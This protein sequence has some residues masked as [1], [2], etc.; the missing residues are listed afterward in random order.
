MSEPAEARTTVSFDD[1]VAERFQ[2]LLRFGRVLTGSTPAAEDLV[3]TAL[4]K[5]YPKWDRIEAADPE[6][7]VRRVMANTHAS[8]WRRPWR[9]R[10]YEEPPERPASGPDPYV[11]LE[12]RDAVWQAL[13]QL[14][15]RQRTALVLRFYEE[16]SM[17]EIAGALGC[18]NGTAKSLVSRGL[19]ALRE[20]TG[21]HE[22]SGLDT[23]TGAETTKLT[24]TDDTS[25]GGHSGGRR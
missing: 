23:D 24:D 4:T 5:T 13:S 9:E 2:P 3:Q 20:T 10:P 25:P 18:R 11:N 1:F 6:G 15:S 8:W 22:A 14:S 17:D 21:L 19:A 7:Y 16:L 12:L